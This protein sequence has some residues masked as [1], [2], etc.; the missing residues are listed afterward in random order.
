[1]K[2]LLATFAASAALFTLAGCG[3]GVATETIAKYGDRVVTKQNYLTQ[4]ETMDTIAVQ[5]PN[6]QTVQAR[7]AQPMSVQALSKVIER[8]VIQET[9][10]KEGQL[11]SKDDVEAEKKLRIALNPEFLNQL[12]GAGLSSE[13]IDDFLRTELAL[14]RLRVMGQPEKTLADAEKYVKDNPKDFE[15]PE[16]VSF[17]WIVVNDE[18][19]KTKVDQEMARST[20][21]ALA[22]KYSIVPTAKQDNGAFNSGGGITPRPLA[23]TD[24]IPEPMKSVLRKTKEGETSAWFKSDNQWVRVKI[25]GKVPAQQIKPRK[26][27]LEMLRRE[28][29]MRDSRGANAVNKKLIDAL[30]AANVQV[31]PPH[32]KKNWETVIAN[33]KQQM[34]QANAASGTGAGGTGG[35]AGTSPTPPT[36]DNN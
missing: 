34:G 2:T 17:R 3:G 16:Q 24:A 27:Q 10:R 36:P 26:E 1:M 15:Q 30:L 12:K 28:L 4:L 33:L 21:G 11:P 19:T 35:T 8:I 25:E 31:I 22:A 23:L 9:A 20:F 6:G 18:A 32:L 13:D 7:P 14:Y 5:L 29:T